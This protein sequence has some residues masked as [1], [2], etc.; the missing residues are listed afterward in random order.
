[1]LEP[2]SRS[3][4]WINEKSVTVRNWIVSVGENGN[5]IDFGPSGGDRSAGAANG[6]S[7]L[8]RGDPGLA[9]GCLQFQRSVLVQRHRGLH[10]VLLHVQS[11]TPID[12]N[13]IER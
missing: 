9:R 8:G 2:Q 12:Y 3:Q 4:R 13:S 11:E 1:M 6:A 7:E 5:P 10:R